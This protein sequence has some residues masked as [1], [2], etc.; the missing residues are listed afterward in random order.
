MH[1]VQTADL[2]SLLSEHGPAIVHSRTR[3]ATPAV[4]RYWAASRNRFELW[5]QT[6]AR[7]RRAEESGDFAS[8]RCWWQDH[9][10]VMEEVLVTEILTRVIAAL[11]ASVEV[12]TTEEETSPITHA[13]SI[14]H[15]EARNRV[16]KI[17]LFGRGNSIEDAVRLNRLRQAVERWTDAMIGRM[18]GGARRS[19]QYAFDSRRAAH[20]REDIGRLGRGAPLSTAMW[21]MNASMRDT[22]SRRTSRQTA[23]PEANRAVTQSVLAMLRPE[24]FDSL[25]ALKSSWLHQLETDHESSDRAPSWHHDLEPNEPDAEPLSEADPTYTQRWYQ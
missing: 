1:C 12:E 8:L 21:L 10:V 2:A 11:T 23:L 17:M 16:Q 19:L 20:Y 22:L 24:L 13:V 15:I 5:H 18:R 9:V 3:F 4:A 6:L 7:Y 25:G 14:A